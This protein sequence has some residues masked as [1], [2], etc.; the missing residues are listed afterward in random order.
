MPRGDRRSAGS[1]EILRLTISSSRRRALQWLL[2]PAAQL[3]TPSIAS[4]QVVR[5]ASTRLWPAQ[6]Y[7]RLILEAPTPIPHQLL[8]LKE[9]HR[10]VLDLDDVKLTSELMQLPIRVQQS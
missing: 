4:A 6:E 5:I 10:I 1:H 2:L 7:T 8:V 9:P 3:V